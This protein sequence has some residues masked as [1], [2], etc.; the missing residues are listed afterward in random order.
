M[1]IK[2]LLIH[3]FQVLIHSTCN[4]QHYCDYNSSLIV[5]ETSTLGSVC[6]LRYGQGM[7]M[8]LVRRMLITH[9]KSYFFGG[10]FRFVIFDV[11]KKKMVL[12]AL[13]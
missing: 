5:A 8:S 2:G 6:S 13:K 1:A 10:V 3:S 11:Y 4:V 9:I 12:D 7:Q